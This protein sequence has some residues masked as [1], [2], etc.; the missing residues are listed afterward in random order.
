MYIM[1][2]DFFFYIYQCLNLRQAIFDYNVLTASLM[3]VNGSL[4]CLVHDIFLLLDSSN[5]IRV[6][7]ICFTHFLMNLDIMPF[8]YLECSIN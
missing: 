6:G 5:L 7:K 8:F 3:V 2:R 4:L 1:V